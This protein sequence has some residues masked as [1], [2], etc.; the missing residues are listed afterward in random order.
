MLSYKTV[1]SVFITSTLMAGLCA[2]GIAIADR[3]DFVEDKA[4]HQ[5]M[6]SAHR[7]ASRYAPENTLA[8]FSKAMEMRADFIEVDV[9]TTSDSVQVC[10]HDGSL[11]RTTGLDAAVKTSLYEEIRKASAGA[12]FG[13][14]YAAEKVPAFEE[15]CALVSNTN[16]RNAGSTRLYVDCKSIRV[17]VVVS[18][19]Q[20]HGLLDSAVFYGDLDVLSEIRKI[21]AVARLM[22]SY[23]GKGD[24]EEVIR[25]IR[26]YAFDTAWKDVSPAL[27]KESH[28][29]GIKVFVDLLGEHDHAVDYIKAMQAGVDLIQTDDVPGV[30][31]S[32]EEFKTLQRR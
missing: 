5:V 7:G 24:L 26:P 6:I 28:R 31:Q 27:V 10:V 11:K 20:K 16:K 19:L 30:Q 8:A 15:V 9:R 18:L 12:W 14:Q 22:P 21:S 13:K 1:I 4:Y 17:K 32:I 2:A 3:G 29:R 25:T 23:P